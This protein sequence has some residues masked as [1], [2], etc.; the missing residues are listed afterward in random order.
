MTIA[1]FSLFL[2][3]FS[4][5]C[6][7]VVYLDSIRLGFKDGTY[8]I[9][10]WALA[11]NIAWELQQAVFEYQAAGFVLQVGISAIWFVLDCVILY[12]YFRFGKKYFPKNL[13][14]RWFLVWSILVLLTAFIV[15]YVFLIEFGLYVGR[16][17]SAFLQNLLMSV[18]F[19][20]MLV[21]RGC[22]EGQ[23]LTIAVSKWLGTL[24]PTIIYGIL[25]GEYM[26]GPNALIL[27]AGGFCSLFDLIYIWMLL[28]T[29]GVE[30]RNETPMVLF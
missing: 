10:F 20:G 16:Q 1:Q 17:Y 8:A 7:T 5:F 24:A 6:W 26:S 15:Q 27:V 18:L 9:P 4:G 12:T 21:S 11:L 22:R 19:V 14:E 3:A 29:K 28:R 30:K 25:G 23:S 2:V 13:Q